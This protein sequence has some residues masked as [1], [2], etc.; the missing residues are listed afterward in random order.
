[1]DI[2]RVTHHSEQS[3]PPVSIRA[4]PPVSPDAQRERNR[5]HSI[6]TLHNTASE[7][8]R[9]L[10]VLLAHTDPESTVK[11]M[12]TIEA[13]SCGE[14][15]E[16]QVLGEPGLNE[17]TRRLY[18]GTPPLVAYVKPQS[19]ETG[20]TV[21][22]KSGQILNVRRAFNQATGQLDIHRAVD[23]DIN[24]DPDFQPLADFVRRE[25]RHDRPRRFQAIAERYGI[26]PKDVPLSSTEITT[27]LGVDIG[28]ATVREYIAS[29]INEL[30]RFDVVPLTVLRAEKDQTDISS[31]QEGVKAQDPEHPPKALDVQVITDVL[32]QGPNHQGAKSFMRI[33]CL[34]YLLKSADRHY[35]NILYDPASHAFSAIDNG[36]SMGLS[37]NVEIQD[38]R[39]E[40]KKESRPIDPYKSIPLELINYH[41]EWQL[42]EEALAALRHLYESTTNYLAARERAKTEAERQALATQGKEIKYLTSL[43]RLL[44]ENEKIAAKE[45]LEFMGRLKEVIDNGRPPDL[46]KKALLAIQFPQAA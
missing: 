6:A 20:F 39:G 2:E 3:C 44:H 8:D 13:L 33:A 27:R 19:G 31:V 16:R 12:R 46:R 21:D 43:F 25:I 34:D 42:D 23:A 7:L 36:Y 4:E 30:V 41:P 28:K 11:K 32:E 18:A 17:T 40:T 45:A 29:R 15:L 35:Q 9:L 10:P 5:R 14:E 1:M 38:E 26:D 37:W 24:H 22:P